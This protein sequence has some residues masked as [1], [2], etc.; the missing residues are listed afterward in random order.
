MQ[1]YRGEEFS[2]PLLAITQEG[3]SATIVTAITSSKARLELHQTSQVL[4]DY[5]HLLFY[6]VYST[7]SYDQVML[8]PAGSCRDIGSARVIINVTLLPYPDG[9]TQSHEV[10]I[11]EERLYQYDINCTIGKSLKQKI[12]NSG[13]EFYIPTHP[14]RV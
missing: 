14:I 6:T 5:C 12:L 8:Y 2:I 9:F 13:L 4:H 3:T 1:V 7:E 11:C 10:C